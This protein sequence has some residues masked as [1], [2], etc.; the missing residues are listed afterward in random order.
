MGDSS[1]ISTSQQ[2]W[3][4]AWYG[5]RRWT[6]W[7]LPLT[8]IFV[9]ISALRR[10]W[11]C[12]Y[13]QTVLSTPVI[14]VGNIS[15][16]G[17]G[18]TPLL[19]AL[20]AYLQRQ[21]FTPGV[22]SRGYGSK[23]PSYPYLLDQS[24]TPELAGDEPLSIFQRTYCAVC[25]DSDRVAAARLLEDQGCDILVSDDGLQ[26][27]RLG[28]DIEIAVVDG[29]RVLGNGFRLP[30]GPLRESVSRLTTVDWV[31]AN[32]PSNNFLK[33]K[34]PGLFFI[35]MAIQTQSF[36]NLGSGEQYSLDYFSGRQLHA[37]AG[38]GNPERFY[39]SLQ[40][41]GVSPIVHT[42]PDHHAYA[43]NDLLFAGDLPLVMTEKDAVKCRRFAQPNWFYLSIDA[44]LPDFFW[45]ALLVKI[46][47]IRELKNS[48]F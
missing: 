39:T 20:V 2:A 4:D 36:I 40:Q 44:Q 19:I 8:W 29:K 7:L 13:R 31:V 6:L 11:L 5:S 42:F 3:L 30:V 48:V 47:K 23:A 46:R 9:T 32:T 16:G 10:W 1:R 45:D 15:V 22:I 35:P 43:E 12:R 28:R 33:D 18:K 38:I 14:V 34:I 21:G 41:L 26:H 24:S 37:V 27:Y 17:T 25:I